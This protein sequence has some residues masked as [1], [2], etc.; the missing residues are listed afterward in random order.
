MVSKDDIGMLLGKIKE[1]SNHRDFVILGS[2]SI[3]GHP[4]QIPLGM[5]V[6]NDVDLYLK[7][8]PSRSD[9]VSDFGEDSDF[10]ETYGYYAD[11][12]SPNMPSL[13]EGWKE[14]LVLVKY[15]DG[16]NGLF[17]EPND[18]AISKYFRGNENDLSWIRQGLDAKILDLA[19]IKDRLKSVTNC[20]E[21]EAEKVKVLIAIDE[22]RISKISTQQTVKP[23]QIGK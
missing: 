8:D 18:C 21:G 3:L 2:L 6:S 13:P 15:K 20:L 14:R 9:G 5:M 10:H 4:G 23:P 22:S 19:I 16:V 1:K 12:V 11:K 17:L 7:N